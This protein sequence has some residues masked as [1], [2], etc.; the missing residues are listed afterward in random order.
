VPTF[1][2]VDAFLDRRSI[3]PATVTERKD[4]SSLGGA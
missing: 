2:Y 4:G 1:F 3:S